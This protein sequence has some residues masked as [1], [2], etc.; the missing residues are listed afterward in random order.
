MGVAQSGRRSDP[1][2]TSTSGPGIVKSVGSSPTAHILRNASARERDRPRILALFAAAVKLHCAT[3]AVL[4][5]AEVFQ[6]SSA[7]RFNSSTAFLTLP[8]RRH[9]LENLTELALSADSTTG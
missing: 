2:K 7:T 4:G 1:A 3:G 8:G 6:L 5:D 9:L